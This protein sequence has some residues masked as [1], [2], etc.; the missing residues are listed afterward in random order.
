[1]LFFVP[2]T[3]APSIQAALKFEACFICQHPEGL[4]V[5][6][7]THTTLPKPLASY[8]H[9]I[10]ILPQHEDYPLIAKRSVAHQ[11]KV[12]N[13]I[14]GGEGNVKIIAGPC[15]VENLDQLTQIAK[16]LNKHGIRLM[17]GGA[18]KPRTSPYSFQGLGHEGLSLMQAVADEHA[19]FT[20]T[21]LMDVRFLDDFLEAGVGVIQI[22]SRNMQNFDLLKTV[23][24]TRT[25]VMLKRGL[26]ATIKEWLLAA[27]YV[28][29]QGNS[30]IILCE[31]GIRSF[32]PSYRNMLDITAI[33]V[34]KRETHLPVIV[35]PSHAAGH[36]DLV[37]ALAKAAIAAGADGL[38]IEIHPN[39]SQALS[40]QAQALDFKMFDALMRDITSVGCHPK[41]TEG[42]LFQL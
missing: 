14:F 42:S 15:S 6:L 26:A 21:E 37:P 10:E 9:L 28:A 17:R 29:S 1:M 11:V 5:F 40:D 12:G 2:Q 33:P 3:N 7:P 31:R 38:L 34:A 41:R 8:Q 16:Q 19:L 20:V 30:Q 4:I 13:V 24:Q 23:G 35:D 39:P 18:F 27:E 25:P 36:A 22:G 32:E